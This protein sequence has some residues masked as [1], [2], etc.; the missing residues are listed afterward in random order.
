[1]T[2]PAQ[3]YMEYEDDDPAECDKCGE[4]KR[5]EEMIFLRYTRIEHG[6]LAVARYE[7]FCDKC[8]SPEEEE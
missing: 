8:Y 2:W 5:A 4:I 7:I 1:M 6:K 3:S